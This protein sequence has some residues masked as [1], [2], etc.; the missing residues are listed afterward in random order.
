MAFNGRF[1]LN[2]ATFAARQGADF[3]HLI[4]LSG[5]SEATLA[6]PE[7][8]LSREVYNA[9]IEEAIAKTED[10]CLGLHLGE[11]LSLSAAGL[12][13]QITQTS[14]TVKQALEYCCEFAN[15]GCSELP[16][17]LEKEGAYYKVSLQ[18]N[19][20]WEQQ[21][22]LAYRHTAEG[23]LVFTL[24]EF[25][26]LTQRL[27]HPAEVHL[28]WAEGP[29]L[30]EYQRIFKAPLVFK[31]GEIAIVLH[32]SQVEQRISTYNFELLRILVAHAEEKSA[33]LSQK[34]GFA[35]TVRQSMLQL[36]HAAFPNVEQVAHYLNVSPRTL[37]RRLKEENY[38]YKQ[39]LKELRQ[40]FA[41]SYL[42]RSDIGISEVGYLLNYA[43]TSAFSRAFKRWQGVSPEAWRENHAG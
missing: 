8:V 33:Q 4:A 18:Q 14:A 26:T 42:R 22:P 6:T 38:T 36:T 11:G 30:S 41:L 5:Q 27:Y 37:Q 21:S 43:S 29:T 12:I 9:I 39:L 3:Q 19:K 2:V 34:M 13:G 40:D 31:R 28:P 20:L 7:S 24:R 16:M 15:L 23:I 25:E 17:R 32:Q 10:P 35:N 1:V